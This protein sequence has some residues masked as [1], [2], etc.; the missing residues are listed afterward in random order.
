MN[1]KALEG[2]A[3]ALVLFVIVAVVL[4]VEPPVGSHLRRIVD[5]M[6]TGRSPALIDPFTM[7]GGAA[8]QVGQ[9]IGLGQAPLLLLILVAAVLVLALLRL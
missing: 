9:A 7:L 3:S 2:I 1:P 8:Q 5:S 4:S 6:T